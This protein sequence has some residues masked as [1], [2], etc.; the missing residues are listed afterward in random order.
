MKTG[1]TGLEDLSDEKS[2]FIV[3]CQDQPHREDEEQFELVDFRSRT[4]DIQRS[5]PSLLT[6]RKGRRRVPGIVA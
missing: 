2:S 6:S 4:D 3:S 5:L 1:V